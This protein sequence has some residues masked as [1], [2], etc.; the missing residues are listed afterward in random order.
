[1]QI[2]LENSVTE[3]RHALNSSRQFITANG[4]SSSLPGL[5]SA[6]PL[7]NQV[8]ENN[9][10]DSHQIEA[11]QHRPAGHEEPS[12]TSLVPS[13]SVFE[14]SSQLDEEETLVEGI[15][16]EDF[17]NSAQD[18]WEDMRVVSRKVL[19]YASNVLRSTSHETTLS[20]EGLAAL[21]VE[22][23]PAETAPVTPPVGS[24]SAERTTERV[25]E[26]SSPAIFIRNISS[27]PRQPNR[28]SQGAELVEIQSSNRK[29]DSRADH[30]Y[31]KHQD[32]ASYM[33]PSTSVQHWDVGF[34]V[35]V[36]ACAS[37]ALT[38]FRA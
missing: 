38:K 33:I 27:N 21:D 25:L 32:G 36:C 23:P 31:F 11:L 35:D 6:S 2:S 8:Q 24:N 10:T 14:P 29:V 19:R 17:E 15:L 12:S 9:N 18:L 26:V 34:P 16:E 4:D 3:I 1:L 13:S 30:I 22:I 28:D 7:D 5:R 37:I 20:D